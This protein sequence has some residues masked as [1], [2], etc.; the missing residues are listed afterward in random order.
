[1][2]NV[3]TRENDTWIATLS[4]WSQRYIPDAFPLV[5]TLT[6]IVAILAIIFTPSTPMSILT[7]WY[8]GFW[9]MLNFTVNV[10]MLIFTGFLVANSRPVN[11]LLTKLARIPRSSRSSVLLFLI[12]SIVLFYIHFALGM[13]SAILFGKA[14]IVE[15]DIKGNKLS[16]PLI[17]AIAGF[18]VIFQAGPTAGSPLL[19]AASGHF[20]EDVIGVLP[21]TKTTLSLPV[22]IM[23]VVMAIIFALVFTS[24]ANRLSEEERDEADTEV[25]MC[26]QSELKK[27]EE[28]QPAKPTSFAERFD[29]FSWIQILIGF[30]GLVLVII[31]I[32]QGGLGKLSFGSV[33]MLFLMLA[34]ILHRKP[35]NLT[36]AAH[37]IAPLIKPCASHKA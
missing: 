11:S 26:F 18:C 7:N 21:L 4:R 29:N 13:A 32:I 9:S 6:L 20:M 37:D 23:N 34:M 30:V 28:V 22:I 19:V 10:A 31:K 25:L 15:Q 36:K 1:M 33:N 24:L 14:M 3:K 8:D 12:V 17:A 27:I 35:A 16:I 5:I 2:K